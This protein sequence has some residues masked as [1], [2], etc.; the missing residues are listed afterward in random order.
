M[1]TEDR[2]RFNYMLLSRLAMDCRYFLGN[3]QRYEPHLW[4]GNVKDQI[5]KMKELW[6]G[7]EEKPQW[8]SYEEIEDFERQ[9]LAPNGAM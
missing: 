1:N 6:N 8:L 7:F 5:A 3:G 9:M 2:I 4:A